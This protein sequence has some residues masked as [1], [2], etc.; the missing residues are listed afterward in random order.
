M[1]RSLTDV[2]T[3]IQQGVVAA[4]G[5]SQFLNNATFNSSS[6]RVNL[7]STA[8]VSQTST[9][10]LV[11]TKVV[12]TST[13]SAQTVNISANAVEMYVES[14]G[15][16]AS[17]AGQS[18]GTNVNRGAGGGAGA[19][20]SALYTGSMDATLTVT[21]GSGGASAVGTAGNAGS[22]TTIVGTQ[23][24]TLTAGGGGTAAGAGSNQQ[25][26][27]GGTA[28]YSS[29]AGPLAT[30]TLIAGGQG[31][32]S[33]SL[34]NYVGFGGDAPRGGA[35]G[36]ANV[37]QPGNVPGGAGSGENHTGGGSGVGARGEVQIWT[38]SHG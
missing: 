33:Y 15:G 31:G 22:N 14:W 38:R 27:N 32:V 25:G 13:S 10:F 18:G 36:K 34:V 28:T 1:A 20:A 3:G 37:A 11:W 9:S 2:L 23:F 30:T 16:G 8:Y 29:G 24:G 26:G 7:V 21:I 6:L 5:L 12:I 4:N 19:Y 35:G 17:G